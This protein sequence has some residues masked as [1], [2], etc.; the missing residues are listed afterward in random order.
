MAQPIVVKK[1]DDLDEEGEYARASPPLFPPRAAYSCALLAR[2]H[3][4][5]P[6]GP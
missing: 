1:D 2:E 5:A 3:R 6:D 4:S